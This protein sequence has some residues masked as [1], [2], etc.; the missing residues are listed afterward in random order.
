MPEFSVLFFYFEIQEKKR[1]KKIVSTTTKKWQTDTA[2][3]MQRIYWL[4]RFQSRQM[5]VCVCVLWLI[6]LCHNNNHVIDVM[7][8][9]FFSIDWIHIHI[10]DTWF[11]TPTHTHTHLYIDQTFW[12]WIK[13]NIFQFFLLLFKRNKARKTFYPGWW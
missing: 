11:H 1:E 12:F 8:S 3:G 6:M 5:C 4:Y 13:K 2:T 9:R 10:L 7:I